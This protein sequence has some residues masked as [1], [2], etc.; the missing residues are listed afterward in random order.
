MLACSQT[1]TDAASSKGLSR[2]MQNYALTTPAEI[3]TVHTTTFLGREP[4]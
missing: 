3:I 1:Y 4:T 2:E